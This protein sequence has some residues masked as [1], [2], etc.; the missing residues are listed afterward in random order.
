MCHLLTIKTQ[1][2][3][4]YAAQLVFYAPDFHTILHRVYV[5]GP[6]WFHVARWLRDAIADSDLVMK[7]SEYFP[8]IT[9]VQ[10][11]YDCGVLKVDFVQRRQHYVPKKTLPLE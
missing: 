3:P 2:Y 8:G 1:P 6:L 7:P 5:D 11:S 9:T 4:A 10:C